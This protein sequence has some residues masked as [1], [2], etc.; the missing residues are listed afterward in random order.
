M[1]LRK[2]RQEPV[3]VRQAHLHPRNGGPGDRMLRFGRSYDDVLGPQNAGQAFKGFLPKARG[4]VFVVLTRIRR[5]AQKPEG[6]KDRQ[7]PAVQNFLVH[8]AD[9]RTVD[10]IRI[11]GPLQAR[12]GGV[13]KA[14]SFSPDALTADEPEPGFLGACERRR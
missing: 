11:T 13:R 10:V 8:Q 2:I 9:R 6:S 7:M 5:P 3:L 4:T 12:G 1:Y 14:S